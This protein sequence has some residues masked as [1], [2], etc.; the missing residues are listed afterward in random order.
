MFSHLKATKGEIVTRDEII[1][2]IM[3]HIGADIKQTISPTI[4]TI[5]ELKM[6]EDLEDGRHK[7]LV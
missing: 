5:N 3:Y 4:K 6:V 1:E 7:I 2:A